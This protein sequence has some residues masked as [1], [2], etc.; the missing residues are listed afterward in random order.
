VSRYWARRNRGNF[1][2]IVVVLRLFLVTDSI[3]DLDIGYRRSGG[4]MTMRRNTPK[5]SVF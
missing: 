3:F 4:R 5:L 1:S 2:L